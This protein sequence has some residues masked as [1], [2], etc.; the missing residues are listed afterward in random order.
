MS[1]MEHVGKYSD[2]EGRAKS[3]GQSVGNLGSN[4]FMLFGRGQ[5]LM[6]LAFTLLICKMVELIMPASVVSLGDQLR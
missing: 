2:F 3:I 5:L 6:S 1:S 4:T